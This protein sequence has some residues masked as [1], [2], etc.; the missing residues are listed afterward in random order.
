MREWVYG[1]MYVLLLNYYTVTLSYLSG[2]DVPQ[3]HSSFSSSLSDTSLGVMSANNGPLFVTLGLFIV[4]EF[5][6]KDENGE[7]TGKTLNSQAGLP[8]F[9]DVFCWVTDDERC[10]FRLAEGGRMRLLEHECGSDNL[11]YIVPTCSWNT[12]GC[13]LE[14]S[15]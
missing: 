5:E 15:V 13:H 7:P 11:F 4:D 1:S 3:I 6:F 12:I 8:F 2:Y 10:C 9:F 14:E